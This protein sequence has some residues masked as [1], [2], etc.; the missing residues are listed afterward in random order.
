MQQPQI[1]TTRAL[2]K[3]GAYALIPP[4][5]L[6]TNLIPEMPDCRVKIMTS[7]EMGAGFVQYVLEAQPGQGSV[8]PL[9]AEQGV[10]AFFFLLEGECSLSWRDGTARAEVGLSSTAPRRIPFNSAAAG[11]APC[12]RCCTSSAT[13]R[14]KAKSRPGAFTETCGRSRQRR[15][16]PY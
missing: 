7:Q 1:L 2:V 4:D 5:A 11:K 12:G 13:V 3:K 6:V 9:A 15:A 8:S 16:A 14:W 10:E